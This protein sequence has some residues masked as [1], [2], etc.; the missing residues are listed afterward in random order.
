LLNEAENISAEKG[1]ATSEPYA[2]HT[3]FNKEFDKRSE[4]A[5]VKNILSRQPL[6]VFFRHAIGATHIATV[7]H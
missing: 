2:P 3:R 4:F 6:V 5:V 7:C 1:L